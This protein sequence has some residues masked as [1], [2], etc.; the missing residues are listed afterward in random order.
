MRIAVVGGGVAGLVTAYGLGRGHDVTLFEASDRLGGHAHTVMVPTEAGEVPVDTGF[1]VFNERHYPYFSA[2]LETLG[3][4]SQLS[5]MS[6]GVACERTGLAWCGT[7]LRTIFAQPR[8]LL[9]ARFL[10]MLR[11]VLDFHKRADTLVKTLPDRA[12]VAELLAA[13]GWGDALREH[14]VEPLAAALWSTPPGGVG[15]LSAQGFIAFLHNHEMLAPRKTRSPWRTICGGSRSYVRALVEATRMTARLG[16]PIRAVRRDDEGCSLTTQT[17]ETERFDHV[18][19]AVHSDTALEI[20]EDP[21]GA[22]REVLGALPY[23]MNE[24]V[25]HTDTS[26]LPTARRAWA[27]WNAYLPAQQ[28]DHVTVTYDVSLLQSLPGPA[29]YLVTLGPVHTLDETKVLRRLRY[30]HPQCGPDGFVAQQRHG[31]ISGVRHTSYCGAWWG[32]GFHE[33]AVRSAAQVLETFGVTLPRN[34][35]R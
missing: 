31:E 8:N 15:A 25:L 21:S 6:F 16:T 34:D 33:D 2:L 20:L 11:D 22:E 32:H 29:R 1:L 27:A 23:Q 19:L 12:S 7:N 35:V 5:N 26:V 3:V 17:G 14:Y 9:R 10:G 18:V 13:G 30:A 24:A 28:V 4:E